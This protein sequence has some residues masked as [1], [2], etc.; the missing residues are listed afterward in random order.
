MARAPDEKIKRA[1]ELYDQ[2][3]KLVDIAA[4]LGVPAGTVRRWKSTH[5]WD[6]ERSVKKS[7][8][9]VT[10][11]TSKNGIEN[12]AVEEEINSVLENSELTEKQKLFCC[13]YIKSFNATKAYQKAY[14]CS[15]ETA[16][17]CGS[18]M[19]RNVEVKKEIDNLKQNRLNR[20]MF[21]EEDVFQ[22]YM[23]IA[24]SD[25]TDYVSF[26]QE[27]VPVMGQFGPVQIKNPITGKK[28]TLMQKVSVVRLKESDEVD[29]TLI[30]EVSQGRDG[31]KIKLADRMK[32]LDWLSNHMNMATE[33]QRIR[34]A[35][36][37]AKAQLD[38]EEELEDD[39]FLEALNGSAREDWDDEE[40]D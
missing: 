24:F 6:G 29:G 19:L 16:V 2:G 17:R 23:D 14:G 12:Y 30:S 32:A 37:K 33:E 11:K 38:E 20:E 34:I 10:K 35:A 26:G 7:E 18:R 22:K 21:N 4:E 15:Y 1:K 39:G 5:K 28:E 25:I 13:Y 8:R 36:L 9:S 3:K 27:E 40:E 31:A